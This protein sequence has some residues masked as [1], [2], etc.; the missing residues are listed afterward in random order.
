MVWRARRVHPEYRLLRPFLT[1][2]GLP[3]AVG[4]VLR[5]NGKGSFEV[6]ARGLPWSVF[7]LFINVIISFIAIIALKTACQKNKPFAE[8]LVEPCCE[9][10]CCP[11]YG[12]S[13]KRAF[14]LRMRGGS[15]RRW[16]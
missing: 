12:S 3:E 7:N 8:I 15:V 1:R 14:Q 16:S 4:I 5:P 13:W 6:V 10:K 11:S 9:D 2:A